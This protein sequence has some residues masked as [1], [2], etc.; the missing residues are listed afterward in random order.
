VR[1]V[2]VSGLAGELVDHDARR[3][4]WGARRLDADVPMHRRSGLAPIAGT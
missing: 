4:P 3:E 2:F 1:N